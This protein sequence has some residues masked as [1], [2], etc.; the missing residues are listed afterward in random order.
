MNRRGIFALLMAIALVAVAALLLRRSAPPAASPPPLSATGSI[1][2]VSPADLSAERASLAAAIQ[3][4][5]PR[6]RA[7]AL[8]QAFQAL[9][10][11]D[12]EAALLAL[13]ALPR[14]GDYDTALFLLLD[15]LHRRDPDRA[16]ALARTLATSR[17]QAVIY[18]VF[19]DTF[20][21]ENLATAVSR[22]ALVPDGLGRENSLRALA[23]VW[24]RADTAAALAWAQQL[25]LFDRSSA[26]ESALHELVR[27]DPLQVIELAQTS[28]TGPALERTLFLA[29]QKLTLTDPAA[30]AG[31]VPLMPAGDTH[32]RAALE[33][34]RALAVKNPVAALDLIAQLPSGS[35]STLA[36]NSVLTSWAA[37]A[38]AAAAQYV[39]ALPTGPGQDAA[40]AHLAGLLA[41]EPANALAW[42][43]A[44]PAATARDAA[45]VSLASAWAQTDPASATRWA[46]TQ[47]AGATVTAALTGALSYWVLSDAAAARDFVTT[48]PA[49]TQRAA[50]AS[51]AQQL[52]QRDPVSTLAWA[53]ILATPAA[54]EAAVAAAYERWFDNA[55]AAARTWLDAANLPSEFKNRLRTPVAR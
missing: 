1:T 48:L 35:A 20:A 23:G 47:P 16:L 28:L 45:L 9:L 54:R 3:L 53:Q 43:Q 34:A 40:A 27:T 8:G 7:R 52:A 39:A 26:L 41:R 21:R 50:A 4:A 18:N 33:V 10:E 11:R 15:A 32:T 55:P 25:P 13:Y 49:A 2:S 29:V 17:E 36:L 5:D 46:S 38:P 6:A 30:A 31:F 14:G 12:F 24:L 51:I 37:T 22:L 42:A 19:F 44:L